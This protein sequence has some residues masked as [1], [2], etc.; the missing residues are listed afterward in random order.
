[1]INVCG[2]ADEIKIGKGTKVLGENASQYHLVH[3]KSHINWHW[4]KP[5]PQRWEADN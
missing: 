3:R 2:V 4:I 5:R 1:M